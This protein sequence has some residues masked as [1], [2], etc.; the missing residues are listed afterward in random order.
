MVIV[1]K[2]TVRPIPVEIV[3]ANVTVCGELTQVEN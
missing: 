3:Y 1:D 2:P